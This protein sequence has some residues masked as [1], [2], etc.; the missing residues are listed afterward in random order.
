MHCQ[1]LCEKHD[2]PNLI[3]FLFNMLMLAAA[4]GRT[5]TFQV[6]RP[7]TGLLLLLFRK[8]GRAIFRYTDGLLDYFYYFFGKLAEP[9]L[10][11]ITD[12]QSTKYTPDKIH[13]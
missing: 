3:P 12:N 1:T 5:Q 6:H 7:T 10:G 11:T 13:T 4:H 8:I 2:Q 9:I